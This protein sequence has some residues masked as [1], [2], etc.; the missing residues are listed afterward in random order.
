MTKPS[1]PR[2]DA[3]DEELILFFLRTRSNRIFELI[4]DRYSFSVYRKCLLL[5][6]NEHDAQDLAQDIW[7]KVYF[8]LDRFKFEARFSTWLK[9]IVVNRCINHLKA[10]QHFKFSNDV[11][12]DE[13]VA[14]PKINN[15]L[16]VTKLLSQLSRETR[17]LLILK[18][19][20]GYAYE[21]ISEMTGLGISAIKMRINRAK[22]ELLKYTSPVNSSRSPRR[23]QR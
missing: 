3:T 13:H 6:E 9:R 17:A 12:K 15:H 4:Y 14:A 2:D 22:K 5:T 18:F 23:E 19:V 10:K 21:E 16:D 7:I 20:E 11:E 8:F 1:P